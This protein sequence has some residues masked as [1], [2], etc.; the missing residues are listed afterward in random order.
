[1]VRPLKIIITL[2]AI[3]SILIGC[4]TFRADREYQTGLKFFKA[5]K[6]QEANDHAIIAHRSNPYEAAYTGLLAWSYLKQNKV[7]EAENLFSSI[8]LRDKNNI[9]AFQGLAWVNYTLHKY[10]YSEKM[11]KEELAWAENYI[12]RRD[13]SFFVA[14]SREYISSIASDSFY[15]LG[16]TAIA[17]G[18]M[19]KAKSFLSTALN[20]SNNFIGH[21]PIHEALADVYFGE[22]D[23]KNA[24][25][26]Y[27]KAQEEKKNDIV[28]I[29]LG[30][31][32]Y[33]SGNID[34]A[35]K[36]FSQGIVTAM[37]KRPFLYGAVFTKYASGR[38][39]EARNILHDSIKLD[40]YYADTID[41]YN[42]I[43]KTNK[44]TL[45]WKDFAAAYFERGD[46][47]RGAYKLEVY[48]PLAKDDCE[49]NLMDAWGTLYAIS[50]EKA[51][52]QFEALRNQRRCPK[53]QAET[54]MGVALLYMGRLDDAKKMF[55][56]ALQHN[57]GNIRA[58]VAR[59]AVAFLEGNHNEAISI[60]QRSLHLLPKKEIYFS[61]PSQALNNLGRS[62]LNTKQYQKALAT[63]QH[64]E[65]LQQNPSNPQ[66]FDGLGWAFYY[67]DRLQESKT[68]FERALLLDPKYLS[69][70]RG[71]SLIAGNKK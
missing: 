37:D 17:R 32:F 7:A 56:S 47:A 21:G 5:G 60:Y 31:C 1:M 64:L 11:F 65:A 30:W 58:D 19:D 50:L 41:I 28:T 42:L 10:D 34:T 16:L 38:V 62:Y 70:L 24:M 55:G 18:N 27:Q 44:W 59:G 23:Y 6:Y 26:H 61:W 51:L 9:L 40:P 8:D 53:D 39:D 52:V 14:Q 33:F 69:S 3:M 67:L 57:P 48:L 2:I 36:I 45:L 66:I 25:V 15:G 29:K 68:A 13:F 54:G 22:K 4:S 46:F 43:V 35:D 49:A 20:Y 71:L 12:N 63:F